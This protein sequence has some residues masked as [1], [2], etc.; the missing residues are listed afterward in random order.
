LPGAGFF[1]AN[2]R[3]AGAGI[4]GSAGGHWHLWAVAGPGDVGD[5]FRDFPDPH[6]GRGFVGGD[7]GA[8]GGLLRAGVHVSHS[9]SGH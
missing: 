8:V 3:R 2:P 6:P 7:S 9:G 1:A 5:D 4:G